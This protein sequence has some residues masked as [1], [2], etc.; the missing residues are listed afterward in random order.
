MRSRYSIDF[1]NNTHPRDLVYELSVS[2]LVAR[3]IHLAVDLD[4]LSHI[5]NEGIMFNELASNY[6][7]HE[8]HGIESIVEVLV[9]LGILRH[10]ND[11]KIYLTPLAIEFIKHSKLLSISKEEWCKT[12]D[13]LDFLAKAD[14]LYESFATENEISFVNHSMSFHSSSAITLLQELA[15][16]HLLSR[17][18][19]FLA[20]TKFFQIIYNCSTQIAYKEFVSI[21]IQQSSEYKWTEHPKVLEQLI[22]I[23]N[24]YQ[25]INYDD[26]THTLSKT[27]L[28][29]YLIPSVADTLFPA[30]IMID[31]C[32]WD[33][34]AYFE[35]SLKKTSLSA[36]ETVNRKSFYQAV[37]ENPKIFG[38]GMAAISL[39]EDDEVAKT[40]YSVVDNYKV[41]IDIAGGFTAGLLSSLFKKYGDSKRYIL[42]EKKGSSEDET[43]KAREK[44]QNLIDSKWKGK[45]N[46]EIILGDFYLPSANNHI[47]ILSNAAYFV[48]CTLHNMN[49][50]QILQLLKNLHQ[51]IPDE[52]GLFIAERIIPPGE[53]RISMNQMV[54]VLMRLLFKVNAHDIYFYQ[55]LLNKSGF[56]CESALMANNY[57]VFKSVKKMAA[58]QLLHLENSADNDSI[59]YMEQNLDYIKLINN[60]CQLYKKNYNRCFNYG[61]KVNKAILPYMNQFHMVERE[62]ILNN[63]DGFLLDITENDVIIFDLLALPENHDKNKTIS[64]LQKIINECDKKQADFFI[65]YDVIGADN[66]LSIDWSQGHIG[67]KIIKE[68]HPI[69]THVYLS[70]NFTQLL[71]NNAKAY[72]GL[73]QPCF[74]QFFE[75][76]AYM[77]ANNI[78]LV[79]EGHEITYG[80]LNKKV[81]RLA[82]Y[83]LLAGVE[84]EL[85]YQET[86]V[87]IYL[88]RGPQLII[89]ILAVLKTGAAF[90]PI[91]AKAERLALPAAYDR[92]KKSESR[93][94]ITYPDLDKE[95]Q[96]IS[97]RE[98]NAFNYKPICVAKD[99]IYCDEVTA[100]LEKTEINALNVNKE[101]LPEN[102]AYIMYTSGSTGDPKGV[103][104]CHRGLPY[105][106]M[107]H[108]NLLKINNKDVVAQFASIGFDA[109]LMEIMMALGCGGKL[110][111]IPEQAY[112]DIKLLRD[113]YQKHQVSI[114]IQTPNML[115]VLSPEDYAMLR[116]VLIV[117]DAFSKELAMKWLPRKLNQNRQIIN[118]YGLTETTI[119]STL[120]EV[121]EDTELTIGRTVLGLIEKVEPLDN[122]NQQELS[123][124]V[125]KEVNTAKAGEL[126]YAG[127][128]VARGY[129]KK[130]DITQE[131]FGIKA[132]SAKNL[133]WYKTGD[134]IKTLF[135]QKLVYI[136]RVDRQIKLRG[137]RLELDEIEL[138]IKNHSGV[139]EARV[140]CHIDNNK[141]KRLAAYIVPHDRKY[142]MT[143]NEM[144]SD[145]K[146]NF[147]RDIKEHL[148]QKLPGFMC[149]AITNMFVVESL[150]RKDNDKKSF[151][152][153]EM[154]SRWPVPCINPPWNLTQRTKITKENHACLDLMRK[155]FLNILNLPIEQAKLFSYEHDF[156]DWAGDS[157][158]VNILLN[159]LKSVNYAD[160]NLNQMIK[161]FTVID[162]NKEPTVLGVWQWYKHEIKQDKEEFGRFKEELKKIKQ[163]SPIE[164]LY[165]DATGV[166]NDNWYIDL[167]LPF[168]C[169]HSLL[170]NAERDYNN[171]VLT[172]LRTK[173]TLLSCPNSSKQRFETA[174]IFWQQLIE[175]H[176]ISITYKSNGGPYWLLGWSSG[177]L[178]AKAVANKLR[179]L[180]HQT[181]VILIDT[182]HPKIFQLFNS[183]QH[184]VY[185]FEIA[186]VILRNVKLILNMPEDLILQ[187]INV[188]HIEDKLKQTEIVFDM[189][190]SLINRTIA[191]NRVDLTKS[192]EIYTMLQT[193]KLIYL[194]ELQMKDMRLEQDDT[195]IVA[196][197]SQAKWQYN[198]GWDQ[199]DRILKLN[200]CSHFDILHNPDLI[201]HHLK[202]LLINQLNTTV[203]PYFLGY[204]SILNNDLVT[205][206]SHFTKAVNTYPYM[207]HMYTARGKV[208]LELSQNKE[209]LADFNKAI[210]LNAKDPECYALRGKIKA[211]LKEYKD[212]LT[213]FNNAIQR[214]PKKPGFYV[215]RGIVKSLL[216]N[217]A[218]AKEDQELAMKMG[219]I[220]YNEYLRRSDYNLNLNLIENALNDVEEAIQLN[221][222][223]AAAF[224]VRARIHVFSELYHDALIDCDKALMIDDNDFGANLIK[225]YIFNHLK[226][227]EKALPYYN[228][229]ISIKPS[230]K[231]LL[232]T[233]ANIY[234]DLDR[235][236]EAASD[237][238]LIL[239]THPDNTHA[240]QVRANA[241]IGLKNFKQALSDC[242]KI[243]LLDKEYENAYVSRA[244]IYSVLELYD[245]ALADTNYVLDKN[246]TCARAYTMRGIIKSKSG[247]HKDA[248][249]DYSL[250]V[251]YDDSDI[252]A[253]VNR[254]ISFRVLGE[255]KLA[256]NDCN[257]AINL[258][259]NCKDAYVCRGVCN[260]LLLN[261]DE[262]L[263][264]FNKVLLLDEHDKRAKFFRGLFALL[265][266][267]AIFDNDFDGIVFDLSNVLENLNPAS[268]GYHAHILQAAYEN[269]MFL[270]NFYFSKKAQALGEKFSKAVLM[271]FASKNETNLNNNTIVITRESPKL[272]RIKSNQF[273]NNYYYTLNDMYILLM[274]LRKQSF[275]YK[276]GK[277]KC[278]FYYRNEEFHCLRENSPHIFL[279]NPYI[280]QN[281]AIAI[282]DDIKNI[283]IP[284]D[285]K[286]SNR[287]YQWYEK[288]R[289]II[290]PI[291]L[292]D[293]WLAVRIEL[294]YI[295][296]TVEILWDDPLGT[297]YFA[298]ALKNN[299]REV[300]LD[301]LRILFGNND[302]KLNEKD[303]RI[304]QI[305]ED[306]CFDSG[307]VILSNIKDYLNVNITNEKFCVASARFMYS[308]KPF[309]ENVSRKN[310]QEARQAHLKMLSELYVTSQQQTWQANYETETV[311][312]LKN[313]LVIMIQQET[314]LKELARFDGSN[315][316]AITE[317]IKK[318]E[319]NRI[320]KVKGERINGG[321]T[322]DEVKQCLI[323]MSKQK[324]NLTVSSGM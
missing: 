276:A 271:A 183:K 188:D 177:G 295:N 81:N 131:R 101:I 141:N 254:A 56:Q 134:V 157:I 250:A 216:E 111:L 152:D 12:Y 283:L 47:P 244:N 190:E 53:H 119:C 255:N 240:Y 182:P 71:T 45:F 146:A 266:R 14:A 120:E 310:L 257:N 317:L 11:Q 171:T 73:L 199:S 192:E 145:E 2:Y 121:K 320:S 313:S 251:Q 30:M 275:N 139:A 40:V 9:N 259:P 136:G 272:Y 50:E 130:P 23:L 245:K 204:S 1:Q 277:N 237:C 324:I 241:Y 26:K 233:R 198:L 165:S 123:D 75:A 256:I 281:F 27:L 32:W 215:A 210:E 36:Y 218:E 93:F 311:S 86:L 194:A 303:K 209:A 174:L 115:E 302:F 16:L 17:C 227:F 197:K 70:K 69:I 44:I 63:N 175:Y 62:D 97:V 265:S 59:K 35:E 138:L 87:T 109:S 296:S 125:G 178:I 7:D 208:Y 224:V 262:A 13:I 64:F 107:S 307:P 270:L 282:N 309:K 48:K 298:D 292:I 230:S 201:N 318:L 60:H 150:I 8:E 214:D 258:K 206:L 116:V 122:E 137:Q 234:L 85:K 140:V 314:E 124:R 294:N 212:S 180:N 288:P 202:P 96:S 186:H 74:H 196:E 179:Q 308:I 112:K 33:A 80:E 147:L 252:D 144:L 46:P 37:Q 164:A 279:T 280:A 76:Q 312:K 284:N 191:N 223:A 132:G 3:S 90:L 169:I 291:V 316:I 319:L 274:A 82:R 242:N 321:Y 65:Q 39:Y 117:G 286:N 142:L 211:D 106:L 94:L 323:E 98:N 158:K 231:N 25:I 154:K 49:E 239:S 213:D 228:K 92:F 135:N 10:T 247:Q 55:N 161:N 168:Y 77:N 6:V 105:A 83:L 24:R 243:L 293:L 22:F 160:K 68:N 95:F 149:P 4:I 248:I 118:G 306:Q 185:L 114:I 268:P 220:N 226:Q 28:T 29:G 267:K 278:Y 113:I 236:I 108:Q 205:A 99:D 260:G 155:A 151:N 43:N 143:L 249:Q 18:I 61:V 148:K 184:S 88:E 304:A 173:Y 110:I 19:R 289:L 200:N 187:E 21:L 133:K 156:Y 217:F 269:Y 322:F 15:H 221:K 163:H 51:I 100:Q 305:A 189:L 79:W 103:E 34:A 195:L 225:G 129:W 273:N 315:L 290:V 238:N 170:G 285:P 104:I 38:D 203:K 20:E 232:L 41:F 42:Y 66:S 58:S 166:L 31:K 172:Q 162:F 5:P 301:N 67:R 253:Y 126:Y 297:G 127:P 128:M 219:L 264:D 57:M 246:P 153:L 261:F 299:I 167:H 300:L 54:N 235:F 181:I 72:Q 263:Q 176:F 89:S 52:S 287:K 91:D 207:A 159:H 84:Q 193:A 102:L 78:A 229:V 222:N